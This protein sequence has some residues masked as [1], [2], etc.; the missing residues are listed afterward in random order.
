[1]PA[2]HLAARITEPRQV[3]VIRI[4]GR[5][6]DL[7]TVVHQVIKLLIRQSADFKVRMALGEELLKPRRPQPTRHTHTLTP[8]TIRCR[9]PRNPP[10][11]NQIRAR[12]KPIPS[13]LAR[14]GH[15][16]MPRRIN[17]H[18]RRST[19]LHR[20]IPRLHTLLH[21]SPNKRKRIKH[22]Q[23]RVRIR[24]NPIHNPIQPI[25]RLDGRRGQRVHLAAVRVPPQHVHDLLR[26]EHGREGAR[27]VQPRR[28]GRDA[29]VR[30]GIALRELHGLAPA[31]R[32]AVEVGE[33]G[34]LGVEAG[35]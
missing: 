13:L 3:R 33:G 29:V 23:T 6:I 34:G 26:P 22:P 7:P 25:T 9:N 20:P 15:N 8:A 19:N 27:R 4:N 16:P 21:R 5:P 1:M 17:H 24:H 10:R 18:R 35:G 28:A 30:G 12:A 2:H 32:A 14:S 11:I 31:L